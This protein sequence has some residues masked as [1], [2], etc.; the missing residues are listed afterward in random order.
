MSH[1]NLESPNQTCDHQGIHS[2]SKILFF[3]ENMLLLLLTCA[4]EAS[5]QSQ[6]RELEQVQT[7]N[8]KKSSF[9]LKLEGKH[10]Q[11][12]QLMLIMLDKDKALQKEQNISDNN[13]VCNHSAGEQ[14][15]S[16]VMKSNECHDFCYFNFNFNRHLRSHN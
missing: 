2:S 13:R 12:V 14:S 9:F 1:S 3:R 10:S 4:L 6:A 16:S 15:V 8:K 5:A 11:D 7:N